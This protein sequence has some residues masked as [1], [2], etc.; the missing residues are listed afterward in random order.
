[1]CE[2]G[3]RPRDVAVRRVAEQLCSRHNPTAF[4]ALSPAWNEA[5]ARAAQVFSLER[6][7]GLNGGG[8][9]SLHLIH[10]L[11][12]TCGS[13]RTPMGGGAV[14]ADPW[15]LRGGKYIRTPA[16]VTP[17]RRVQF[18]LP[19]LLVLPSLRAVIVSPL[20]GVMKGERWAPPAWAGL[21]GGAI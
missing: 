16:P 17:R 14:G 9:A 18:A 11:S 12:P 3:A 2:A 21:K 15:R 8:G 20:A 7:K 1:M 13:S 10:I 19:L 4:E 6:R 5:A